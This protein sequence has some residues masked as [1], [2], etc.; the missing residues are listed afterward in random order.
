MNSTYQSPEK[1]REASALL[2]PPAGLGLDWAGNIEMR[3]PDQWHMRPTSGTTGAIDTWV[4]APYVT[5]RVAPSAR[6]ASERLVRLQQR[7]SGICDAPSGTQLG[8][9]G[10]A[11][12]ASALDTVP[13]LRRG[14]ALLDETAVLRFLSEHPELLPV[15]LEG[16][17]M[18]SQWFGASVD[19]ELDVVADMEAG[20]YVQLFAYVVTAMDPGEVLK[21][22]EQFDRAWFLDKMT[23]VGDLLCYS[24]VV[25]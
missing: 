9:R 14:Y 10:D 22:F 17:A 6:S 19:V 11:G 5:V 2:F 20:D 4:D 15:L 25:R 3:E 23:V 7:V 12:V 16:R 1:E 8:T 21:R 18:V 24:P 13:E